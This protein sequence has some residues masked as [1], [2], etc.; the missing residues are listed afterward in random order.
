MFN[1]C[2]AYNYQEIIDA[3]TRKAGDGDVSVQSALGTMYMTGNLRL[4]EGH[5]C[6]NVGKNEEK[7]LYWLKKIADRDSLAKT[8]G[9][10]REKYEYATYIV[11]HYYYNNK[12]YNNAITYLE[13]SLHPKAVYLQAIMYR[14]GLGVQKNSVRYK[15]DMILAASLGVADAQ[16]I[17]G[18]MVRDVLPTNKYNGDINESIK[19]LELAVK[20]DSRYRLDKK[21]LLEAQYQLGGTY[22]FGKNDVNSALYWLTK[23]AEAGHPESSYL[24][25]GTIYFDVN[26]SYYNL[27]K[28]KYYLQKAYDGGILE[29]RRSLDVLNEYQ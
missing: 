22:L 17:C 10:G 14:D 29:A 20:N 11:G 3:M 25:G 21:D 16:L 27:V 13:K 7:G 26:K 28:A 8:E 5:Q 18:L 23:A 9:I 2:Y 19:W 15:A 4:A 1:T 12:D 6:I 24:L